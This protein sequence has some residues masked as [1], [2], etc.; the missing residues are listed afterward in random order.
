M[1]IPVVPV[2]VGA[3]LGFVVHK[4]HSKMI[5]EENMAKIQIVKDAAKATAE[6]IT[7]E[8]AYKAGKKLIGLSEIIGRKGVMKK[9]KR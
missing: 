5:E 8:A 1:S 7:S 9:G 2:I 6:R 3:G 4:V